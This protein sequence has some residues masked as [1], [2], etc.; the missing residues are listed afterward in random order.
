MVLIFSSP[1]SATRSSNDEKS[2]LSSR[3]TSAAWS[4]GGQWRE[5]DDVGKHHGDGRVLVGDFRLALSK[6]RRDRRRHHVEKQP[7]GFL[8][9]PGDRLGLLADDEVLEEH[10]APG[11]LEDVQRQ[12]RA[13]RCGHEE[14]A[15]QREA[16]RSVVRQ[17]RD[18]EGGGDHDRARGGE[19]EPRA[20]HE[21]EEIEQHDGGDA[22]PGK[23]SGQRSQD[24][25]HRR[26]CGGEHCRKAVLTVER[27]GPAREHE[28][29]EADQRHEASDRQDRRCRER[30]SDRYAGQPRRPRRA[31]ET[32]VM[33]RR[34]PMLSAPAASW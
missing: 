8:A 4:A 12:E 19:D 20:R 24:E 31:A 14:E 34:P 10:P 7:I 32:A 2:A 15:I 11:M 3:T 13:S 17:H 6:P 16:L 25:D 22:V 33:T 28:G 18:Q 5:P 21:G 26:I 29:N 23:R 1:R 9:L 27:L 30:R